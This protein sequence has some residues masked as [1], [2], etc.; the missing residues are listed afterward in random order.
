MVFYSTL[1]VSVVSQG[2][3][4]YETRLGL[5]DS[6]VLYSSPIIYY[7]GGK[8][9]LIFAMTWRCM[10]LAETIIVCMSPVAKS[11]EVIIEIQDQAQQALLSLAG[12]SWSSGV[13]SDPLQH[14]T[15]ILLNVRVPCDAN[16]TNEGLSRHWNTCGPLGFPREQLRSL[17]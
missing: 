10:G 3:W 2:I 15:A 9:T 5:V 16:Q 8:I 7:L 4:V 14:A 12:Q 6:S 1:T 11:K 13:V 17:P